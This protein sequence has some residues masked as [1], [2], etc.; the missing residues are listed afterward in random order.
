MTL[1]APPAP[2][3]VTRPD[4]RCS[5]ANLDRDAKHLRIDLDRGDLGAIFDLDAK[6]RQMIPQDLFGPPLGLA[7]LELIPVAK[8]AEV[9][10]HDL[11]H[12]RPED[13]CVLD[14]HPG[15]D[16]RLDQARPVD[17]VEHRRLERGSACLVMRR[18][19]LLDDAR[20]DAVANQLAGRKQSGRTAPDD[21]DGRLAEKL[22]HFKSN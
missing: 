21:Q 20:L 15:A 14:V 8:A 3:Q 5:A 1:W 2:K 19:P 9:R 16:E 17:D 7:A 22:T 13:F 10:A 4:D 6:P 18:K 12:A 11:P